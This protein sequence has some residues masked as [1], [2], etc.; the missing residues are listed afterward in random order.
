MFTKAQRTK[1][2]LRMAITG[3]SGSGKTTAALLLAKG[4]G[5]KIALIDTEHES[6]S[7]YSHL[8]DFD[9][10][11]LIPP[12]TP[13]RYIE[14]IDMADK[15]GYD[16]LIIDSISH[17]W[18]GSGGC[19]E[20]NEEIAQR[21]YKGN[22]WSAW[23][24][25]TP[26]HRSFIERLLISDMNII[27]TMRSK[28]ETVQEKIDGKTKVLKLGMKPIQRD[29]TDYEFTTVLDIDIDTHLARASKDRTG[30]FTDV[31]EI[32]ESTGALLS[33]WLNDGVERDTAQILIDKIS[34]ATTLE[35]LKTAYDAAISYA[36]SHNDEK[37]KSEII[38][39]KNERKEALTIAVE[40]EVS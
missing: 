38:L 37:L 10:V 16:T 27:C 2:K 9:T 15:A 14:L 18:E 30:L 28:S 33:A 40:P 4:F 39:Y 22:S 1:A 8:V 20:M 35:E 31:V 11:S 21:K 23:N 24:E 29:G 6:A 3:V 32:N 26:R 34:N 12:F 25:V 36:K 5:G 17:E 13:E 7:L 19:I